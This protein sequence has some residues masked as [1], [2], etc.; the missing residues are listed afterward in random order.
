MASNDKQAYRTTFQDLCATVPSSR[1]LIRALEALKMQQPLLALSH[2]LVDLEVRHTFT[3]EKNDIIKFCHDRLSWALQITGPIPTRKEVIYANCNGEGRARDFEIKGRHSLI[4]VAEFLLQRKDA[5]NVDR[6]ASL[7]PK[8]LRD[9]ELLKV[10]RCTSPASAHLCFAEAERAVSRNCLLDACVEL[11][12]PF[13]I[14]PRLEGL[15]KVNF[16]SRYLQDI[17][18]PVIWIERLD[19]YF[20]L[21]KLQVGP[22]KD[23]SNEEK[24]GDPSP[25]TVSP[26]NTHTLRTSI[27]MRGLPGGS[28]SIHEDDTQRYLRNVLKVAHLEHQFDK[29]NYGANLHLQTAVV[30]NIALPT[31][32]VALVER[33]LLVRDEM[34]IEDEEVQMKHLWLGKMRGWSQARRLKETEL[35]WKKRRCWER[36]NALRDE[37]TVEDLVEWDE[38][39]ARERK[40]EDE[41]EDGG[42]EGEDEDEEGGSEKESEEEEEDEKQ[43]RHTALGTTLPVCPRPEDVNQGMKVEGTLDGV[44]SGGEKWKRRKFS[45]STA[46]DTEKE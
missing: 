32:R 45:A 46:E 12:I 6:N 37:L 17:P 35:Q 29:N 4:K 20:N 33:V 11:F 14:Q 5:I 28:P 24:C 3:G 38:E 1:F 25:N 26:W 22:Y 21:E 36:V 16:M 7:K 27:I 39:R 9:E 44:S 31:D 42:S 2:L 40:S 41:D 13:G 43:V 10:L 23:A 19:W 15:Q 34:R 8:P 18:D 30:F